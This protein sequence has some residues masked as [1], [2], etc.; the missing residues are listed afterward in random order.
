M[1]I[2]NARETTLHLKFADFNL[3]TVG[4]CT[5]QTLLDKFYRF[6]NWG[7]GAE[8]AEKMKQA[9]FALRGG[10][11]KAASDFLDVMLAPLGH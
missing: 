5:Q 1:K 9:I 7:A 10:N 8:R 2:I 11:H 3:Q 6:A 4:I